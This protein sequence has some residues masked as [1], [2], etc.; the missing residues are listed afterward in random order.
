M[1]MPEEVNTVTVFE[2]INVPTF[3]YAFSQ[4][5]TGNSKTNRNERVC[6]LWITFLAGEGAQRNSGTRLKVVT[7]HSFDYR[8]DQ[9]Q[10]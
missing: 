8:V 4:Q 2:A 3:P 5:D 7:K 10:N 1:P 6:K 9:H